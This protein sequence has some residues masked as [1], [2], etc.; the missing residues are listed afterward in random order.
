MEKRYQRAEGLPEKL[1]EELKECLK[2]N[3]EVKKLEFKVKGKKGEQAP[4]KENLKGYLLEEGYQGIE[5]GKHKVYLRE[6]GNAPSFNQVLEA[7]RNEL[8][9]PVVEK[10]EA[11]YAKLSADNKK[12]GLV[13]K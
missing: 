13:L 4:L 12:M 1:G 2:L 6:G 3:E 11:R 5:N 9:K 10:L 8:P 7:V